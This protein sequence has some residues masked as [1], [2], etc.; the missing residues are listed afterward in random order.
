MSM[1]TRKEEDVAIYF[2]HQL[3]IRARSRIAE[4]QD[5]AQI[6]DLIKAAETLSGI[7]LSENQGFPEFLKHLTEFAK[8][9]PEVQ[10]VLNNF[11]LRNPEAIND[12]TVQA[13]KLRCFHLVD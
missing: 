10:I 4:T 5:P 9:I 3:I 7:V 12:K 8:A 11:V 13:N 1:F 6:K 2:V